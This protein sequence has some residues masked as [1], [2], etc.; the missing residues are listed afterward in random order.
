MKPEVSFDKTVTTVK[1][2]DLVHTMVEITAPPSPEME[3]S[4]SMSF[5]SSTALDQ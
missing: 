5:L 1:Q 2:G 3:R 4:L